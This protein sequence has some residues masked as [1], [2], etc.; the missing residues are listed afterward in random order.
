M[1]SVFWNHIYI[2]ICIYKISPHEI[3]KTSGY[4][5]YFPILPSTPPQN[6]KKRISTFCSK[7]LRFFPVFFTTGTTGTTGTTPQPPPPGES[8]GIRTQL[9]WLGC[10]CSKPFGVWL[11]KPKGRDLQMLGGCGFFMVWVPAK[12][13]KMEWQVKIFQKYLKPASSFQ[14]LPKGAVW[15]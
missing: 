13:R 12:L 3:K 15:F 14:H 11:G 8:H 6:K 2:C 7:I 5:D 9:E 4:L 1:K 10:F